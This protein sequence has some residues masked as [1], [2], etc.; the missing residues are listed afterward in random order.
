M[1]QFNRPLHIWLVTV[2]E[3]L[4]GYSS[5]DRLW[6]CGFLA[7][8]LADRGH[9]VT[10]WASTFD[11]F[12]KRYFEEAEV[13]REINPNLR[14]QFL[15]GRAY[16]KNVSISRFLNHRELGQRFTAIANKAGP[17]DVIAI[18]YP[19]IELARAA[20]LYGQQRAI[21]VFTDIRD[22]WPDEIVRRAP[23]WARAAANLLTWPLRQQAVEA[24]KKSTGLIAI[25]DAYLRWGLEMAGRT[26]RGTDHVIPLG[27]TG[28][29]TPARCPD[30]VLDRLRRLGANPDKQIFWFCGTFV[31]N[32]DLK[33]VIDAARILSGRHEVQFV[34][35]GDGERAAEWKDYAHNQ[36]NVIFTGW[37]GAREI[38]GMCAIAYAGLAAYKPGASMS[39]PNKLFEYMSAGLP[40]VSCLTG[41]AAKIIEESDIGLSYSAGNADDLAD[42]VVRL[43]G[44]A[45][46][47]DRQ[48]A[49]ARSLFEEKYSADLIYNRYAD[50][51]ESA[52]L[53]RADL[54]TCL[55]FG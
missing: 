3:P 52:A 34:L 48:A 26:I 25:S 6:R 18:S 7:Q 49:S 27:Y 10:W 28:Q 37:L 8:L 14:L 46:L 32:I 36:S 43:A 19:P 16:T 38:A 2:G 31:G 20:V 23:R 54:P 51:L 17:P 44:D 35:S 30:D 33:T 40:V 29:A 12:N 24:L 13:V 11:H 1:D 39:L 41:E 53:H 50:F 15:G 45:R 9:K 42:K 22:L 21:P 55:V 47:R 5:G 4:P